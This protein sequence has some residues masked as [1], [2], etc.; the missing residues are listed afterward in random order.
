MRLLPLLLLL[1]ACT[2]PD[3]VSLLDLETSEPETYYLTHDAGRTLHYAV[4]LRNDTDSTLA[5]Y[6]FVYAADN[7]ANPPARQVYPPIALQAMPPSRKFAVSRP[8]LGTAAELAPSDTLTLRGVL[9]LPPA[10]SD[11]RPIVSD[12]FRDLHLYAYDA[13][14][15]Q[16]YHE[17]WPIRRVEGEVLTPD[18]RRGFR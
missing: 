3:Q 10:W 17:M 18:G 16:L 13:A 9:P 6:F 1:A 4:N 7:V 14:G 8:S 12:G 15:R 5:L 2:E 11:G